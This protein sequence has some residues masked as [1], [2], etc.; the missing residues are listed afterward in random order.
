MKKKIWI[1]CGIVLMALL[2]IFGRLLYIHFRFKP[3]KDIVGEEG[4]QYEKAYECG[5]VLPEQFPKLQ[6]NLYVTP[7]RHII[8]KDQGG[9]EVEKTP[10]CDLIIHIKFPSGYSIRAQ[11]SDENGA[12]LDDIFLNEKM[13]LVSE[14]GRDIYEQYYDEIRKSFVVAHEVFGILNPPKE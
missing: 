13:E 1:V 10:I 9:Y 14:E 5:V 7:V 12:E 6:G 2:L 8:P 3:F 4:I 11:V